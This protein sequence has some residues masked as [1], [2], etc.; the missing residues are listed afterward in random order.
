M[1]TMTHQLGATTSI[2]IDLH[3]VQKPKLG[4]RYADDSLIYISYFVGTL[5]I[6]V[7]FC[8]VFFL[9]FVF[10]VLISAFQNI[11]RP[12]IFLLFL[13]VCLFSSLALVCFVSHFL[14]WYLKNPKRF[15]FVCCFLLFLFQISKTQKYL[16]FFFGFVKFVVEFS[17]P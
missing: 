17:L 9:F 15:C 8:F 12:K 1:P 16:L 4:G 6:H 2:G 10:L 14:V 13:F 11:K 5:Y 3:L 7:L